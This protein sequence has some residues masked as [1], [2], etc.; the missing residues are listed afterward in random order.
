NYVV[1]VQES[2]K[3]VIF[4]HRIE[5]GSADKSYGI[6]VARLA[7]VPE[8]VL[9]RAEQVLGTLETRHQ[10]PLSPGPRAK[11]ARS[12]AGEIRPP[13][14]R[15]AAALPPLASLLPL[16]GE[17]GGRAPA[18]TPGEG[19][20]PKEPLTRAGLRPA[21]PLPQGEREEHPPP[22]TTPEQPAATG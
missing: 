13:T 22:L 21:C 11:P 3:D 7:G 8:P 19:S 16:G 15:D 5:P 17:G 10:L 14:P 1:Q 12:P 4:L 18:S 2:E 20:G 6:H 9:A